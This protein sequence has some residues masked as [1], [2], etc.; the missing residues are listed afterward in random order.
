MKL[1]ILLLAMTLVPAVVQPAFAKE[2]PHIYGAGIMWADWLETNQLPEHFRSN[3]RG[4]NQAQLDM[5]VEMGGTACHGSFDWSDI[6][7]VRGTYDWEKFDR[8][9]EDCIAR[10]LAV[11]AYIGNTP[12]WAIPAG[13][14]LPGWRTPPD[15]AYTEDFKRYCEAVAARYKGKVDHFFFWNEPDGCSWIKEGCANGDSWPLYVKWLKIAYTALK[16][17]NPDSV[18]S[19]C[20]GG[21]EQGHRYIEGMY[22]E[23]VKGYLDALVI[24]PYPREGRTESVLWEAVH[25]SRR[26]MVENGDADKSLWINEW[27]FD[28]SGSEGAPERLRDFLTKIASPEY[29]YVSYCRYLVM[30]DLPE[31]TYG[32]AN[33]A[34]E[35]R[36]IYHAFREIDKS[37]H[38]KPKKPKARPDVFGCGVFWAHW[39][40]PEDVPEKYRAD[41]RSYNQAQL[42]LIKQMGGTAVWANLD[43]RGYEEERGKYDWTNYDAQIEDI[44]SRGLTVYAFVGCTPDWA[45]PEEHRQLDGSRVPPDESAAQDFFNYC[46]AVAARY[47][48]KVTYYMFWNEPNGC[49]WVN[50]NCSNMDGY[51]LYT[52]WL[53]R[54][55]LGL[56]AGNPKAVV[57]AGVIDYNEGV[58][59]GWKYIEGIYNEGG[60]SFFDA[61]VIHPY[62]KL[63]EGVHWN[64]IRDTRDLMIRRGD[65]RKPIWIDE[66]G[67]WN[68]DSP[69]AVKRAT[70]F[71]TR[72]SGPQYDH[73]TMCRYLI[74]SPLPDGG[75]GLCNR[76]LEPYPIYETFKSFDKSALMK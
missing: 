59:E 60:G 56:K 57:G 51:P 5:I 3:P 61:V 7:K 70:E 50:D 67:W 68:A 63:D 26:V 69:E 13:S 12:D 2:R 6:E 24:H 75:Y 64:A 66:W 43:W 9:V 22:K 32:L 18:V 15:E 23:G 25:E 42:D 72:I 14:G 16:K 44:T 20:G 11:Y 49:G 39:L 38:V 37:A 1:F 19:A 74:V 52:K 47:K 4:Y 36:P 33:R 35:P 53:K 28:D 62:A 54:A 34:L 17:G 76:A 58:E 65:A 48:D 21:S 55:Y 71:L 73:V 10:G 45:K 46:K 8:N 31:N 29:D 41:M 27:G 30:T 40:K